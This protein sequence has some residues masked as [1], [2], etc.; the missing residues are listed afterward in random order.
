MSDS[1]PENLGSFGSLDMA[2]G[3]GRGLVPEDV[4]D[5]VGMCG[6]VKRQLSVE[7]VCV[8]VRVRGDV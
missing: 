1:S 8:G 7:V 5:E 2:T 3:G 6:G 4:A